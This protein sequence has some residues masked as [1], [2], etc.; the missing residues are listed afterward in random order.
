VSGAPT[1]RGDAAA[2]ADGRGSVLVAAG[3]LLSRLAGLVRE[4]VIQPYLGLTPAADAFRA[5]VRIPNLLQNLFGEGVLSASFIPVYS[6]LLE[7]GRTKEADRLAGAVAGLLAVATGALALVTLV[8]ARPVTRVLAI[9]LRGDAFELAVDLVRIMTVGIAFLV[10]SAWCLGVLNSHRRFFLSYA[11]PVIWNAAQIVA[12]VYAGLNGWSTEGIAVALAWGVTLGGLL[13]F[14]VQLPTV[15]RLAPELRVAVSVRAAA[16]REVLRRFGPALLGRGVT[17]L[18][19]FLDIVLVSL[20]ASGGLAAI[21]TGQV[22]FLLPISLFVMSITAAELPELSRLAGR[23]PVGLTARSTLALRRIMFFVMFSTV[24]Y[25]ALGDLIVSL[26]YERGLFGADDT[27]LVWFVV[28]A[29]AL[30]MPA[31][32]GS[33]LLQNTLFATGDTKGPA[34]IAVVR[35]SIDAVLTLFLMFNL[36]RIQ[37]VGGSLSGWGDLPGIF[38]PLPEEVRTAG[39][40]LR[41]GAVGSALGSAVAAWVELFLLRRLVRRDVGADIDPVTPMTALGVAAALAFLAGAAV[42]LPLDDLPGFVAAPVALAVAGA[43]YVVVAFRTGVA[44]SALVLRPVR[45]V[46]WGR[47]LRGR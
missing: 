30:G 6:R 20:A 22:L 35:I 9:G 8:L 46:L 1:R 34:R 33:R 4:M 38:G 19:A 41:L 40:V 26:L 16:T 29:Y 14:L 5:A 43:V 24:A 39:D 7:E 47:I 37:L 27:L 32:A 44:E 23:D 21:G 13:Q 17:Q 31:N 45:R 2:A 25:L 36:D 15:R 28:A 18:S 12:V 10:L 11:S 3:I 42:K